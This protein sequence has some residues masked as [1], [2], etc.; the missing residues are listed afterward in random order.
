MLLR[1]N[2]LAVG[3]QADSNCMDP[4]H[5]NVR[6][7]FDSRVTRVTADPPGE[8]TSG[9]GRG[10][11]RPA[12]HDPNPSAGCRCHATPTW[13]AGVP[14]VPPGL[15]RHSYSPTTP[16]NARVQG[17]GAIFTAFRSDR[18]GRIPKNVCGRPRRS[19][20]TLGP[21]DKV[22]RRWA[23]GLSGP[24]NSGTG[25]LPVTTCHHRQDADAT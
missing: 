3:S 23:L 24:A 6:L 5:I 12:R 14:P 13:V 15:C 8:S 16:A 7:L 21:K 4:A 10:H 11:G 2:S 25:I 19:D 9:L 20:P 18:P 1:A 22:P 17:L